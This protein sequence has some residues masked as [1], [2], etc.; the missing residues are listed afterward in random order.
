L[1]E[2]PK[3]RRK[4]KIISHFEKK[5][6]TKLQIV[7]HYQQV[8][9]PIFLIILLTIY[10]FHLFQFFNLSFP[11]YNFSFLYNINYNS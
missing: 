4:K 11:Y 5:N 2:D 10:Y 9:N 1:V 3:W 8:F 6:S 7:L